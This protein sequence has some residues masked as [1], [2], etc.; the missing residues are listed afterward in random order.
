MKT[1][2]VDFVRGY[3][4]KNSVRLHMPG[5]KGN[6]CL[7]FEVFDITEIDGADVLYSPDGI[8]LESENNASRLFGTAHTYY[9]TEGSTLCI[10]AMLAIATADRGGGRPLV[11]A[12]RNSHKAFIYAAALLDF[13]VEWLYPSEFSHLCACDVTPS[14]LET[15]LQEC[16]RKPCAVYVTS[17]D[18]LGNILDIKGLADVCHAHGVPLLVD[19][20]HGAYLNFLREPLHPIALGADMCCDSAHKTLPVLTGGAYLHVSENANGD[21]TQIAREKL[22]LFAS[23]SPSY[24]ILQSLDLCNAYLC[25]CYFERLSA[26]C[27]RLTRMKNRLSESGFCICGSEPLKLTL[28][29]SKSGFSGKSLSEYLSACGIEIEFSDRDCAVMMFTPENSEDDISHVERALL[30]FDLS[31]EGD[32]AL[33]DAELCTLH[34]ALCTHIRVM[35]IHDA[36]FSRSEL[37]STEDAEGRICALPCVSCPPAVP[38]IISGERIEQGHIELLKYYGTEQI[39]VVK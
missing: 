18:Y 10:K 16:K 13:D 7:G 26:L 21:Y 2:I 33:S 35:S 12:T 24:L 31:K 17:P 11:F 15:A 28:D 4:Q 27:D 34:S 22:S 9:S 23:T 38:V 8:I 32:Q 37:I 1:P 6:S 14:Q 29:A 30:S 36:I 39:S 19:N 5:H 20:A 25:D 3:A